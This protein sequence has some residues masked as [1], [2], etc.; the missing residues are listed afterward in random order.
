MKTTNVEHL[1]VE[2]GQTIFSVLYDICR[3]GE[4]SDQRGGMMRKYRIA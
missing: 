4:K 3:S 2:V 1:I